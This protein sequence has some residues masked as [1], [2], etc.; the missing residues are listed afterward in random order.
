MIETMCDATGSPL[1]LGRLY[2]EIGGPRDVKLQILTEPATTRGMIL[3]ERHG[4][5]YRNRLELRLQILPDLLF[6]IIP[7]NL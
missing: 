6:P 4:R 3:V 5:D 7:A 2:F 1:E